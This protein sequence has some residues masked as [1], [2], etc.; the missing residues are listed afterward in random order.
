VPRRLLAEAEDAPGDPAD[1]SSS[2]DTAPAGGTAPGAAGND[3]L[4]PS[5]VSSN[6]A[7]PAASSI[8]PRTD[9]PSSE[10]V[11]NISTLAGDSGP[12]T[13]AQSSELVSNISTL[14]GGSN[15]IAA[16]GG[17]NS[18]TTSILD[19]PLVQLSGGRNTT[20]VYTA[21]IAEAA[22]NATA[23]ARSPPSPSPAPSRVDPVPYAYAPAGER[24][25]VY[26]TL[27]LPGLSEPS[28]FTP[29]VQAAFTQALLGFLTPG[30]GG[31][32]V[33]GGGGAAAGA[34]TGPPA[35]VAVL[36]VQEAAAGVW[37][38]AAVEL[39]SDRDDSLRGLL[40]ST[41]Q[42]RGWSQS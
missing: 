15:S 16:D 24:P 23:E 27:Q 4:A 42:V 18:T 41:L 36:A 39:R 13:E 11:G 20:L 25:T 28:R 17:G 10:L 34:P 33:D 30:G 21:A 9:A 31:A 3:T 8:G 6:S 7:S 38:V 37:V 26:F 5:A 2:L 19:T 22:A 40:A 29:D 14:A 1:T 32:G 35:A 12:G